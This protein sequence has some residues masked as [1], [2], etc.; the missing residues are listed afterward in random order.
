MVTSSLLIRANQLCIV[1]GPR[2]GLTYLPH[3]DAVSPRGRDA[4]TGEVGGTHLAPFPLADRV[5]ASSSTFS[6]RDT[7]VATEK[8]SRAKA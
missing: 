4:G 3:M 8:V 5:T 1:A 7:M 2:Q 6:T